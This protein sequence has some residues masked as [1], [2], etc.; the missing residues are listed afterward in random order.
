MAENRNMNPK[1]FKKE[2]D[3]T[4]NYVEDTI[5]SIF[6]NLQTRINTTIRDTGNE[7][8]KNYFRKLRNQT[9]GATTALL[10]S[11]EKTRDELKKV[12]EG[13]GRINDLKKVQSGLQRKINALTQKREQLQRNNLDL[14]ARDA[15]ALEQAQDKAE[16][17]N[18]ELISFQEKINERAGAGVRIFQALADTPFLGTLF[19]AEIATDEIQ[20]NVIAGDSAIQAFAKGAQK[21]FLN[22]E[23]TTVILAL[24][25]GIKKIFDFFVSSAF[26]ADELT[27]SVAKNLG[28]SKDNAAGVVENLQSA[29]GVLRDTSYV[30]D[31]I[32]EAQKQL[33]D[34]TGAVTRN[35]NTQAGEQAFLTKFVGMQAE[36]AALLNV[37]F[38]NQGKL[39]ENVYDNV[40]ATAN[41]A[42]RQSGIFISAQSILQEIGETSA[43]ILGNFAF[44]EEELTKAVLSTRR[45]GVTLSQARN[46]AEGL[47]DFESSIASE[48]EA[49]LLTG[50]QFNFERA[51]ALAATGDIAAATEEVLK[52]T[53]NLTDEQLRSP[54]IQESIAKATG[55]N[56]DELLRARQLTRQLN[57]E[58]VAYNKL[59]KDAA[60]EVERR[61][62]ENQ[63]LQ[64]ASAD[65]IK[66]NLTAQEQFNNALQNAKDQFAA[67]VGSGVLDMF[68]SILPGV[69]K[70]IAK[71]TFQGDE[72]ER[73][74]KLSSI[75]R[76]I[77]PETGEQIGTEA[78]KQILA[79][80]ESGQLK[81]KNM[82]SR[83]ST[84]GAYIS[85]REM[86]AYKQ[87]DAEMN[88]I[89]I[90]NAAT[91]SQGKALESNVK[92]ERT[93]EEQKAF[94]KRRLEEQQKT[95]DLLN[96]LVEKKYEASVEAYR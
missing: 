17:V 82:A 21:A 25:A 75:A 51:R 40:N 58:S 88:A 68:T 15:K 2:M 9:T 32:V 93:L 63:I 37:A 56:A 64:G 34:F 30:T 80:A 54:I 53:Q 55:L 72:F 71:L 92:I 49:E 28:I 57:K 74:S 77:D 41:A 35:L 45:L 1:G 85:A 16:E 79:T 8:D 31:D 11:I 50:R 76:T 38:D 6:S 66:K 78:A 83:M 7:L 12:T 67:L 4:L 84:R 81:S 24:V 87:T 61:E 70:F 5:V 10:N 89:R 95:N 96:R 52:Q 62:I 69:L 59:L 23:R 42:A 86:E 48:L 19:N 3:D 39:T 29:N 60:D 90:L 22:L 27:T 94:D 14:T 91:K 18:E 47:L 43:D 26:R 13:E 46:I 20:K 36:G 33:V 73:A 65:Q 44:S